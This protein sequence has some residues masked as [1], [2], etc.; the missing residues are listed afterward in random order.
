MNKGKL[1]ALGC[2]GLAEEKRKGT[3]ALLLPPWVHVQG[4]RGKR[5]KREAK[6]EGERSGTRR[7]WLSSGDYWVVSPAKPRS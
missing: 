7:N 3:G 1:H 6:K 4:E 2:G 5:E